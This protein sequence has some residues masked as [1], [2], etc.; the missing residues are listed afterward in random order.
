LGRCSVVAV[1][2]L[3]LYS[4]CVVLCGWFGYNKLSSFL[5]RNV[6]DTIL[7]KNIG[8][9]VYKNRVLQTSGKVSEEKISLYT[10][11]KKSV[12]VWAQAE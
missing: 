5:I 6:R 1:S 11:F 12:F 3:V 8:G 9:V 4:L 7:R 10:F 2:L